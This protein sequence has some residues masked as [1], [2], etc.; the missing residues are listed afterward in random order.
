MVHEPSS[1]YSYPDNSPEKK[2]SKDI[3]EQK[4]RRMLYR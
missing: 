1:Y 3:I 4:G 2:K